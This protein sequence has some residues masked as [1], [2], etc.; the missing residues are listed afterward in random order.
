[1]AALA[2]ALIGGHL[3]VANGKRLSP[4]ELADVTLMLPSRGL[5][6]PL[7]AAFMKA[8]GGAALLLPRIVP[9]ADASTE[10]DVLTSAEDLAASAATGSKRVIGQLERQL[11]LINPVFRWAQ[12]TG[13]ST[14]PAQAVHLANE[15]AL[16]MDMLETH[17]LD[18]SALSKIV[19]EDLSEH[20]KQ[21]LT[22]LEIIA[23]FWPAHLE[24]VGAISPVEHRHRILRAEIA[25]LKAQPPTRPVIMAGIS[26]LDPAALELARAVLSLPGGAI[27]LPSGIALPEGAV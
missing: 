3:P 6:A 25:R 8:S 27:V 24:D 13:K 23:Q 1:M 12:Q 18:A 4:L 22:F 17:G 5:V 20:W 19:P 26:S 14:S 21:T 9:I 16:L 2:E 15:L 10:L 11:A 7:Q